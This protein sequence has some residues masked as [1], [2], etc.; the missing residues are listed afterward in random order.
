M[1]IP[2]IV[3]DLTK[4]VRNNLTEYKHY[5]LAVSGGADSLVLA[6]IC[7]EL[8][9]QGF[10]SFTICHV[11]HGIRGKESL[12]D[13]EF[14]RDF[15]QKKGL[16]YVGVH[17]DALACA[18]ENKLSLEDAARRLRYEALRKVKENVGAEKILT[19]HQADDQAETVLWKFLRGAGLEGLSGMTK[20][21]GDILRPML[22]ITRK[23]ILEYLA[24]KN[25]SYKIDSTNANLNYTRNKI[26]QELL[27]LLANNYNESINETLS[28]TASILSEDAFCLEQL[29]KKEYNQAVE[30]V[31]EKEIIFKAKC[32]NKIYPAICKR[33]LRQACFNLGVKE[34]DFERT[35]AIYQLLMRNTGNKVIELP[36]GL[37]VALQNHKL[38][39]SRR[40]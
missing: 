27:P 38:I 31:S 7:S 40:I 13:M 8:D 21:N 2:R 25:L 4:K 10:A 17:V 1:K 22:N 20:K 26:R 5:L 12:E 23:E 9:V 32:F 3:H 11:E 24:A 19:A 16:P 39:F 30:S 34:L 14:V 18:K 15:A 36:Q 29:A 37:F 28:R 35:E 33:I 6:D